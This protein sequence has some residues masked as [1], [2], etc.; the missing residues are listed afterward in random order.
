MGQGGFGLKQIDL[1][2]SDRNRVIQA[3]CAR[4]AFQVAQTSQLP[5]CATPRAESTSITLAM[6]PGASTSCR[7]VGFDVVGFDV[8]GFDWG[9]ALVGASRLS[10]GEDACALIACIHVLFMTTSSAS[11]RPHLDLGSW[12]VV[13]ARSGSGGGCACALISP[14]TAFRCGQLAFSHAPVSPF[15]QD[16]CVFWRY[17]WGRGLACALIAHTAATE[18]L[19]IPLTHQMQARRPGGDSS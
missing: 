3:G 19:Q 13:W 9:C 11:Q 10:V 1:A 2:W 14:K 4:M 8:V 6:T 5:V 7:S 15:K 17:P 12:D 16:E 18:L